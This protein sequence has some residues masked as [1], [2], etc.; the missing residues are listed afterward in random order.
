MYFDFEDY[1]PD[2][3]PV[4]R[5]ISW[6]E[7]VLLSI[8]VHLLG[9]LF[10]IAIPRLFP[11]DPTAAQRLAA[12]LEQARPPEESPRFVYVNPRVDLRALRP[13]ERADASD[14]DRE[15]RARER[16]ENPQNP[17]PFSRGNTPERVEA[18]EEAERARGQGPNPEPQP[19][20]QVRT[21]PEPDT[22]QPKL[23]ESQSAMVVPRDDPSKSSPLQ[24]QPGGLLGDALRNL[25]RQVQRDQFSNRQ[26]AGGNFGPGI[27]FDT[28][29]VEFGPWLRRFVE[30]VKRNWEPLIPEAAAFMKGHVVITFN[31]HKDGTITD[32]TVAA[33][34][35]IDGF[36]NAA[37]GAMR[38]SNP[39]YPLPPEYPSDQAFFTVTFYYNEQPPQ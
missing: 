14:Q 11:Y 39:T 4:G 18:E 24:R 23:P 30:Q 27:Q 16:A 38:A 37:Y 13:P 7:G 19:E 32:L 26:G 21:L 36:N 34:C 10:V 6:R 33:P 25:Q 12:R 2:I 5:V 8:I 15:A 31:I 35:P 9:V 1:R 28:K 3:T 22:N 17:L 29:G 20:E